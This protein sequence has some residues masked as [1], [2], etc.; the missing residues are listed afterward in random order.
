M[1]MG[2]DFN[3]SCPLL[4][5]VMLFRIHATLLVFNGYQTA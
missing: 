5:L 2:K 3:V 4:H 1:T